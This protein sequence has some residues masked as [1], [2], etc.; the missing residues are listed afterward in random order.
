MKKFPIPSFL[1]L[2]SSEKGNK[3]S[4]LRKSN[5]SN[6]LIKEF[7]NIDD[8]SPKNAAGKSFDIIELGKKI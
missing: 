1:L 5:D 2:D 6:I 8:K 7:L 4:K 3:L